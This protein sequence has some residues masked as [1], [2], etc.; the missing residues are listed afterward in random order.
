MSKPLTVLY[1][2]ISLND[3][4]QDITN[5]INASKQA[6]WEFDAVYKEEG[7][8][9]TVPPMKRPEFSKMMKSLPRNSKIIVT[10]QDRLSRSTK[11]LLIFLDEI[12]DL[13]IEL[14]IL[15][16]PSINCSSAIGIMVLTI[17]ASISAMELANLKYRTK[18]GLDNAKAKGVLLGRP[19]RTTPELL[20]KLIIE[21]QTKQLKDIS[22]EYNISCNT[23]SKY[24]Q[25]YLNNREALNEYEETYHKRLK[26]IELNKE[27]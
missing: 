18:M 9:G 17:A 22:K 10:A 13:G 15:Q 3:K 21:M 26:Q 25:K 19:E 27:K 8:S 1:T 20:R 11:D 6:G 16:Y 24:K 12:K 2:R 4:G 7:V 5:Q 23:L 14:Y